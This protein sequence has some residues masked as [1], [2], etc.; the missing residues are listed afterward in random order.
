MK[1]AAL[2]SDS[3]FAGWVQAEGFADVLK[4]MGHD[5]T[6]IAVP[7]VTKITQQDADLINHPILAD[8]AM[9]VDDKVRVAIQ[10]TAEPLPR[11]EQEY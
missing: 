9:L 5:V 6:A 11:L 3:P 4:R 8:L 7:P 2:Y 10:A 1:I